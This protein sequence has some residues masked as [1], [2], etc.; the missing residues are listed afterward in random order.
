MRNP[1]CPRDRSPV[2]GGSPGSIIG[3]DREPRRIPGEICQGIARRKRL[4]VHIQNAYNRLFWVY[5]TT[6]RPAFP[7]VNRSSVKLERA[8][9]CRE[10]KR[11]T[12]RLMTI[13][14]AWAGLIALVR[15]AAMRSIACF[16]TFSP[17]N[18]SQPGFELVYVEIPR[19]VKIQRGFLVN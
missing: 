13:S 12:Q 5:L 6:R 18:S 3:V 19:R 16:A 11:R 15:I 17:C 10:N 7:V 9:P 8:D 1:I 2:A 4:L 14:I